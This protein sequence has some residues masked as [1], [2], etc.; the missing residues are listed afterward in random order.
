MRKIITLILIGCIAQAISAQ[1]VDYKK[2]IISVDK[3]EI[4]KVEV[5]KENLGLTKNF[6]LHS[7]TGEKL[8]IAVLSMEYENDRTDNTT[9]YYRFT[10]VPTDQVGIFK[11]PSLGME[12]G[13]AKLIGSGNI[14]EGNTLNAERVADLIAKK[15]VTP[16]TAVNYS[17]VPRDMSWP[18][19]LTDAQ[20]I[21]QGGEEIGFFTPKGNYNGQDTYEFFIP[22]GILVATV[23]FA[24]GNN[25][26]NFELYTPKDRQRRIVTLPQK[27]N[28]KFHT[29]TVDPNA[30]ILKRI[31]AWLVEANYL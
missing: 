6:E 16:R 31:T 2:N 8:V 23:S 11:L 12:K 13:F 17:L 30:L 25:A 20:S 29:S 24:G 15:G 28:V 21:Q 5:E 19:E 7:M 1:K 10:F 22:S 4:G 26:R 18:I 14:V 27:E 9:M 3:K